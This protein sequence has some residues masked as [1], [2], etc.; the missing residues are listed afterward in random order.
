MSEVPAPILLP[1]PRSLTVGSGTARADLVAE[2]RT[3]GG[4]PG[5]YAFRA[6][7]GGGVAIGAPDAAGFRNA[8]ATLAQLRAQYGAAIPAVEIEDEPAFATR[9]VMLDISR[10]R[11]PTMPHLLATVD[12]LAS[13]KF[14][15]LQLYTEHTFAYSGHEEVWRD[16]S[17]MTPEEI[18]ALDEHCRA[19]GVE[20]AAN[21]NCFGHLS[22]WLR[23]PRYAP[24]AET[25]GAW[26]FENGAERFERS[27]PFSLCPVDP[28]SLAFVEDLL[29]QLLPCFSG[30]MVNIGCDET[31]DVGFG[32][33]REEV[34]RRGRAAVYMEFVGRVAAVA[35]RLGKR[36]MFWADIAL[37]HP[38][39]IR[40]IPDD[41]IALAWGYEPD[42]DWERWCSDLRAAG[43]EVWVCPGTSS[44][45]SITGRTT[46]RR[47]NLAGAAREGLAHGASGYLVTDWGDS[48]HHQQ[49]PVALVALAEA[50]DAAWTGGRP[51]YD[52]RAAS[53]HAFGDRSLA[54]AGWL[55][56]LGNADEPIRRLS[57]APAPDGS[58]RPLRNSSA[59]FNELHAPLHP[60]NPDA[61]LRGVLATRPSLWVETRERLQALGRHPARRAAPAFEAE[62]GHAL[63]ESLTATIKGIARRIGDLSPATRKTLADMVAA[64]RDSH[65]TLWARR[66]R[67]GGLESSCAHYRRIIDDLRGTG[68]GEGT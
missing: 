8:R 13:L 34:A 18:R 23:L 28:A 6:E 64:V 49:W 30:S 17:P 9:G 56:E 54:L 65:R 57:G 25:H 48:G 14:N 50:A 52:P 43:R 24:L 27:G 41:M 40:E 60:V 22:T 29:G 38:E 35:R 11:V 16:A 63:G 32:R 15:H 10:D 37:S 62:I 26:V 53:L 4:A 5:S 46:E 47:A 51:G 39:S 68:E 59:L 61:R 58:A 55:D 33:S 31:F 44:W 45:R 67:P 12:L 7:A 21:Q 20:L 42:A 2:T 66:S 36:P 19:R 3:S 1:R